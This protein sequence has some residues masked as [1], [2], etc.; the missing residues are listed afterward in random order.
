MTGLKHK[1]ARSEERSPCAPAAR[2][3]EPLRRCLVTGEVAEKAHLLRFVIGPAGEI[4]PDVSGRLP[5]RGLW[6]GARRELVETACRRRLFARALGAAVVPPDLADRVER[7]LARHCLELLGL[8]RRA[9]QLLAG[10]ETAR[11]ALAC[12]DAAVLI[13]ARDA[14]PDGRAKMLRLAA[15]VAPELPVV[16]LFDVAELAQALGYGN[17]VHLAL[18]RGALATRFVEAA[19]RLAGF[20]AGAQA[21]PRKREVPT[22]E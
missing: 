12:G 19:R 22:D 21:A 1:T 5:G 2:Q 20:R 11:A 16:A 14:S 15:A 6:I 13:E 7:L 17:P 9:G 18:R 10:F 3:S 4:T 8:A